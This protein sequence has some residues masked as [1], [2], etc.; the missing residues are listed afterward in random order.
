MKLKKK[1]SLVTGGS[2]GIGRAISTTLAAAGATVVVNYKGNQ[3]AADEVVQM[4]G[5]AEGQALAVQADIGKPDE[6]ERL[7]KTT[8]ER[9][10][11]LDI[12]V[13]NA[14]VTRDTLLPRMKA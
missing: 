13:N 8:L 3:A 6:V 14:G 5:E 4:I 12:L 7:F 10:G 2:R 9:L 11:K 1:V